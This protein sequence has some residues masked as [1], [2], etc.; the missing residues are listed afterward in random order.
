MSI[1]IYQHNRLT[2][3]KIGRGLWK[4]D[5]DSECLRL[6]S[7]VQVYE[8]LLLEYLYQKYISVCLVFLCFHLLTLFSVEEQMQMI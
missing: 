5:C 6:K 4:C 3:N 8:I 7:F 2:F 1:F